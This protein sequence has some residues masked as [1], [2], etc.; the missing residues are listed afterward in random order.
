MIASATP[1]HLGQAIRVILASADVDSLIAIFVSTGVWETG[2]VTRALQEGLTAVPAG[3][4]VTKPVLACLMPEQAGLSLVGSGKSRIPCYAFPE[5]A[6]RVLGKMAAYAE[7]RT[8]PLGKVPVF[9]DLDVPAARVVCREA[10][11][12]RGSGWLTTEEN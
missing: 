10:L 5:V 12:R 8:R 3:R 11:D 1:D 2:T 7:W 6:G 4:A 9:M